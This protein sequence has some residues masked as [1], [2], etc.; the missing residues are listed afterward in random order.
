MAVPGGREQRL[1]RPRF[2]MSPDRA[3]D[4]VPRHEVET[5]APAS[6]NH[7]HPLRLRTLQLRCLSDRLS[8]VPSCAPA[9]P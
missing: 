3:P 8:Q 6:P 4:P 2:F 5:D 9:A 1:G 7:D